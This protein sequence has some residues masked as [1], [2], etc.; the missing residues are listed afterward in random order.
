M[1][2]H[3]EVGKDDRYKLVRKQVKILDTW[4]RKKLDLV[5]N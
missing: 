1:T 4:L 3:H 5:T 2:K